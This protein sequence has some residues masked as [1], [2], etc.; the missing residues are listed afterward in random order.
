MIPPDSFLEEPMIL[1]LFIL[2]FLLIG[3]GFSIWT[4]MGISGM[5]YILI[6]GAGLLKD[7]GF[8]DG[9]RSRYSLLGSH[10]FLHACGRIDELLRGSPV[11]WRILLTSL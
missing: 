4:S 11:N 2:L 10:S 5:I 8:N 9:E 7:S 1:I 6:R 3:L